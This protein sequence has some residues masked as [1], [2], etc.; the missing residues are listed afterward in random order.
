[1]LKIEVD[2]RNELQQLQRKI[3]LLTDRNIQF[4]M[5]KALSNTAKSAA[6]DL[7]ASMAR[8]SGGPIQGGAT[9]WT[10]G[11]VYS[12]RANTSN[13]SAEVG[14]R[15]NAQ[16]AAGRYLLPMI[17][18]TLPKTKAID[19]K[20]GGL[21]R[22]MGTVVRPTSNVRLTGQGNV[23]RANFVKIVSQ[24]GQPGGRVFIA[25]V[26]KGSAIQAVYERG[27]RG[28]R[29]GKARQLFVLDR[30]DRRNSTFDLLGDLE[31]SA[32]RVYPGEV[33]AALLAELAR[34]GIG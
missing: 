27:L 1:M 32:R 6:T 16:R 20:L 15:Q 14:I 24:I 10:L 30:P 5:A 23:T 19:L 26:T 22:A 34:A 12:T 11:A 28:A 8:T 33:R 31:K 7:R 3:N 13:L 21:A 29:R 17:R 9:R 25:P 2:A 18:G 4:A